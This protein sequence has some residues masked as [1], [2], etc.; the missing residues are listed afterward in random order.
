MKQRLHNIA[1]YVALAFV[2]SMAVAGIG[3]VA[4]F[5]WAARCGF[6]CFPGFSD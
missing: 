5:F 4:G 3:V 6:L 2:V 1:Y